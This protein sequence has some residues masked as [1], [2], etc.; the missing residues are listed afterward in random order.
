MR[1]VERSEILSLGDY[2]SIREPFRARVIREKKQRR[3]DFGPK[4][5]CLFENHDTVLLQIQE[6]LR[7]ER[8]TREA[9]VLHEIETYNALIPGPG[10]LSATVMIAIADVGER[11]SFLVAAEGFERHVAL[12]VGGELFPARFEAGRALTGRTSAVHY[13]RFPL[14]EV[15]MKYVRDTPPR[16]ADLR[17]VSQ[18]EVYRVE[19]RLP[20]ELVAHIREDLEP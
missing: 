14:G 10:E 13:F 11:D 9:S 3:V 8:I 6:M 4:A 20:A 5:S 12:S 17:L 16:N 15:A 18:H 2:E 7:T 1:P 19:E